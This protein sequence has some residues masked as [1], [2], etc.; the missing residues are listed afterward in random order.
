[1]PG[2]S[3]TTRGRVK[4][5]ALSPRIQ[6][7]RHQ[8]LLAAVERQVLRRMR[9]FHHY[10]Y[11]RSGRHA[12]PLYYLLAAEEQAHDP[13]EVF[14]KLRWGGQL[15]YA[16]GDKQKVRALL[17]QLH[18]RGYDL[19]AG[20]GFVR[21]GPL[22]YLLPALAPKAHYVAA[23]KVLLVP[24]REITERFTYH[25]RLVEGATPDEP[26]VLKE[27]PSVERV[28]ARLRKKFPKLPEALI[29][30]RAR[31]FTDKIFPIFLTREAAMLQILQRDLPP[32]YRRRVPEAL[33]VEKDSRGFVQL[34]WM[35]WLRNGGKP[36]SQLEFARQGADL[37]RVLHEEAHI[38]H[39]DLR[40]DN[41]V[42]T[43]E[44]VGFVDFGS[45]VRMGENI[46]QSPLLSTL[47]TELMRTS[48]IQRMLEDMTLSGAVT[49]T[50]IKKA[51]H[52]VDPAVDFFY[53]AVQINSPQS[54]PELAGLVNFDPDSDEAKA[55]AHLTQD[56]LK[57]RDP[58]HPPYH[59][60]RQILE[61]IEEVAQS[62]GQA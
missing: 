24:P 6:A 8:R 2:A 46:G 45:A 50:A 49:S 44:G 4:G 11:S 59:S 37:L 22:R 28:A 23:R 42:I 26:V 31:K 3:A 55:L 7:K 12:P 54:N 41:M 61:G 62:L 39:L 34:L 9:E 57:P 32:A 18:A 29:E 30:K 25:V 5:A 35:R 48:Q 16:S 52:Q 27:V 36:L 51:Y 43:E 33:E 47:F 38:M 1:M 56:I 14:W 17:P 15:V 21:Y 58:Q 53:L 13:D 40:L 19:T 20:P 10:G 60:A